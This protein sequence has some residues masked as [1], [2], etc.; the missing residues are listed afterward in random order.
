MY[1]VIQVHIFRVLISWF[2]PLH[3]NFFGV[4]LEPV[5]CSGFTAAANIV[6]LMDSI[7]ISVILPSQ[8]NQS[9]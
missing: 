3:P 9:I 8:G 1:C 5:I 2:F 4:A 7:C 6:F